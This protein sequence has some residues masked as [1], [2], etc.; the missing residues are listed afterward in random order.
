MRSLD[1]K[2][3]SIVEVAVALAVLGLALAFIVPSFVGYLQTNT[4]SE[5]RSQAVFLAQ[6]EF[7]ALRIQDSAG[8]PTSGTVERQEAYGGRTFTLRRT[9]CA[10]ASLCGLGSRHIRVEVIWNGRTVYAAETVYTSLR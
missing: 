10:Q 1:A 8:L 7:E 6:R 5:V 2:G 9:Y 4:A 3:L